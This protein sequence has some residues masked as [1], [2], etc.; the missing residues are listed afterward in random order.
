MLFDTQLTVNQLRVHI[1]A[2]RMNDISS[3][4]KPNAVF[5]TVI[6]GLYRTWYAII[7]G[8]ERDIVLYRTYTCN[9]KVTFKMFI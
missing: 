3:L 5:I 8:N 7:Y 9:G 4:K 6:I 1:P 2:V